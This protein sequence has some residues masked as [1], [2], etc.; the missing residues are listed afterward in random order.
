MKVIQVNKFGGPEAMEFVDIADPMPSGN[1]ELITVTSIGVNYADTHQIENGYLA[2]QSLP[3]IPGLEV[4]GTTTS[5]RRVLASVETGGYAQK[6]LANPAVVIDIPDGISD[7]QALCMLVQGSTAWHIL[8]TLGH[9]KAGESVVIHAAAGGV[10]T[11]AVQLAKLWGATVIAVTSS[12]AKS[13]L[14]KSLGADFVVN[15]KSDDLASAMLT[16]NNG[17]PID[18]ILE[19]VGGKTFDSSLAVL[20]PFGRLITYGN[21]SRSAPRP[22]VPGTLI[23]GTKTVTGFWLAHCFGH[24]ELLNDVITELFTLVLSG[25]LR[26][27]IGENFPLSQAA[28]A[29]R[30]M[31]ARETTGKVTLNPLL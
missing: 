18:L 19:M 28:Q 1:Q 30:A 23:T 29:H 15:A 3:L 26:P 8:K 4:V 14:V 2:P 17:K 6:A 7:A 11:I 27:V 21:A 10:G 12:D 13:Q 24:R 16:A 25:K 5:G 22:I 20:A 9:V 31:L